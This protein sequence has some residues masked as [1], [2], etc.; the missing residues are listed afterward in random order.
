MTIEEIKAGF[1]KYDFPYEHY[2]GEG[3]S[4]WKFSSEG[5]NG[6]RKIMM[7]TGDG[8]AQK[9]LETLEK[10]FKDLDLDKFTSEVKAM[11]YGK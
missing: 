6:T 7:Q 3:M 5:G 8:G 9:M 10:T 4:V 11:I 1:E 2:Q